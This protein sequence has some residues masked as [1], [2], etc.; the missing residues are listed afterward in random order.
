MK[1]ILIL[2]LCFVLMLGVTLSMAA[3]GDKDSEKDGNNEN[4]N[5]NNNNG[6]TNTPCT[7]HYDAQ[8][9]GVCDIC[10]GAV[11]TKD[12]G[13]KISVSLTLK[14]DEGNAVAGIS[15]IFSCYESEAN[16]VNSAASDAEGK[17]VA[18]L[19]TGSYYLIYD[20]DP[21]VVGNYTG[22]TT[23]L[24]VSADTES[25]TLYLKNT[26]PNGTVARPFPL[27]A[28]DDFITIPANTT[29]HY[30]VYHAKGI[31]FS[32]T[33]TGVSVTA[34]VGSTPATYTPDANNNIKFDL[35]GDSVNAVA[36]I[37]ITNTTDTEATYVI[38]INSNPGT[39]GNPFVL[40]NA[41][42]NVSGTVNADN[43]IYYV[44]KAPVAGNYT[45]TM[46]SEGTSV[47]AMNRSTSQV[48]NTKSGKSFTIT[49]NAGDE[50]IITCSTSS[51]EDVTVSFTTELT[52]DGDEVKE[53]VIEG[54]MVD[55]KPDTN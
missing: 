5:E 38:E 1:K 51:T 21:D 34:K 6:G 47:A 46:T 30:I 14:D 36:N 43:N 31:Y 49:V 3:C 15:V 19:N 48:E 4:S 44:F 9:D 22:E 52:N 17:I 10:G 25:V 37:I 16:N 33:G 32:L 23:E 26:T 20:Y 13:D 18:E 2:L 7:E 55:I 53:P 11:S 54:P 28:N 27:G 41:S 24:T 39:Y 50:V 35:T 12:D 8:G 42:A 45:I 40:D 29:Y